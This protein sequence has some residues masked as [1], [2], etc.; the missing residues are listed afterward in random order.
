MQQNDPRLDAAKSPEVT[1]PDI[2]ASKSSSHNER[3]LNLAKMIR[4]DLHLY[5]HV[6]CDICGIKPATLRQARWRAR[7]AGMPDPLPSYAKNNTR[8]VVSLRDAIAWLQL[9]GRHLA[10][11]RL[12][13][14]HDDAS[15]MAKRDMRG[16]TRPQ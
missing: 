13:E 6:L 8:H 4:H 12:A 5:A 11:L 15:M 10:L 2:P 9:T 14:W 1:P 16:Y 7:K 3:G